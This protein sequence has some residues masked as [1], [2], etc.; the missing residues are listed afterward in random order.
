MAFLDR[1][2]NGYGDA[3]RPFPAGQR[4]PG[5]LGGQQWQRIP[6]RVPAW[7]RLGRRERAKN[8]PMVSAE[9]RRN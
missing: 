7:T 8:L 5:D 1:D 6:L 9:H 2:A 3:R 4:L